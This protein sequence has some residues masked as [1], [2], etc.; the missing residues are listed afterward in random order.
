[1]E[2]FFTV[3]RIRGESKGLLQVVGERKERRGG[4]RRGEEGRG[5]ARGR[6]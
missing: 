1:L 3:Q 5:G 4:E 2:C 6:M